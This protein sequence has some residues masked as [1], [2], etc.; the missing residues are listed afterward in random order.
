M[1]LLFDENLS[2]QLVDLLADAYPGSRHVSKCGLASAD[3]A[4]IWKF[5]CENQLTIVTKDSD[6]Q[7]RTVLLGPPPKVIWI[8]TP[9]CKSIEIARL[10]RSARTFVQAFIE[11]DEGTCLIL[12]G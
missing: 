5:A 3:D 9:N 12:A 10:L 11:K 6:F 7:E 4:T 2:P 1:K 8:R